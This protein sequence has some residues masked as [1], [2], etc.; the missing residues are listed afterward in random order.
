MSH[1][2]EDN[3]RDL[4]AV[5]AKGDLPGFLE[6]CT[7]DVT[8]TVPG[9]AAVSGSFTKGTF[10]DLIG[11]VMSRSAGTFQEDVLDVFAND[12]HG[13]LLLLH[14]FDREGRH[15]EYRTA[16]VVTFDGDKVASWEE[17]PG[18]MAEFEAAWGS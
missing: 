6:G 18:S 15:F 17:R 5:F 11:I 2:N 10:V 8:F 3:L 13:V 1:T 12:D 16:H 7:D 9:H 14:H 4:Y